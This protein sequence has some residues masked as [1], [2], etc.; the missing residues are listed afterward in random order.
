M[1]HTPYRTQ[2]PSSAR[3]TLLLVRHGQTEANEKGT[4]QGQGDSP[5]TRK[6]RLSSVVKADKLAAFPISAVYCSDLPRARAT[7]AIIQERLPGLPAPAFTKALREI[8]FGSYTG[9]VKQEVME[10]INM[11]KSK[12]SLKY[13]G[14]ESGDDM[15]AR[16][17]SFMDALRRD[18]EDNHALVITHYGVIET[19]VKLYAG[20]PAEARF[21][22]GE[23]AVVA[24]GFDGARVSLQIL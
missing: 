18:N 1:T 19:M 5:L 14:G 13:P 4:I 6:G 23:Q 3:F 24:L 22:L 10:I 9:A 17:D 8:D 15:R 12:T 16:V 7:L 21:Q 20:A 2:L 11:H